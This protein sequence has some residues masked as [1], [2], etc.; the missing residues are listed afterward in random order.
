[1]KQAE[2]FYKDPAHVAAKEEALQERAAE[3]QNAPVVVEKLSKEQLQRIHIFINDINKIYKLLGKE[4]I[5][6]ASYRDHLNTKYGVESS[7]DLT[8]DQAKEFI[9]MLLLKKVKLETSPEAKDA[10]AA[11]YKAEKEGRP[12]PV[13]A[14]PDEK[15]VEKQPEKVRPANVNEDGEIIDPPKDFVKEAR[16]KMLANKLSAGDPMYESEYREIGIDPSR[17]HPSRIKKTHQQ[18]AQL[19]L[20][21]GNDDDVPNF[22]K[23]QEWEK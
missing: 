22:M 16:M 23:P 2:E 6:D 5:P 17:V 7:K 10:R 11:A 15:P 20:F 3:A 1:M 21:G 18:E 4:E 19:D 12:F 13:A 8:V 9:E 14:G